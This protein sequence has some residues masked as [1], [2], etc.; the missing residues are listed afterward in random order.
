MSA[1]PVDGIHLHKIR[2][3]GVD[4]RVATAGSA[5]GPLVLFLHGWPESWFS[6]RHQLKACAVAGFHAVAPDM[7]GYGSTSKP[8]DK[9]EY[10]VYRLAGDAIG[11]VNALGYDKCFLVGHDW[12]GWLTWKLALLHPD[13]FAAVC[14]MSVP[15][16]GRGPAGLLT[17]LKK[18]YG[19]PTEA[20]GDAERRESRFFYMLHHNLSTSAQQYDQDASEALYR[21]YSFLPGVAC[22][23][24]TPEV[25]DARMYVCDADVPLG[26]AEAP[27]MWRRMPRPVALPGWLPAADFQYYV[28][29]FSKNG[30]RGGLN[31]Y[32]TMDINYSITPQLRDAQV[33]QPVL[34]IGGESDMVI[35][36]NG[37]SKKVERALQ[38]WCARKPRCVFYEGAG[39]WIQQERSADVNRELLRFLKEQPLVGMAQKWRSRL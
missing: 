35:A 17:L 23:P 37:G 31:W 39:H 22:E 20:A 1:S 21:L 15:Y 12:G 2:A 24:G 10:N 13:V 38:K 33:S 36:L 3:N 14:A 25:T 18:K 30:F 7:R 28:D 26:E 29:E 8:Q 5:H 27:G 16:N 32:K 9:H 6:W 11:L 19:D 4:I 34:F